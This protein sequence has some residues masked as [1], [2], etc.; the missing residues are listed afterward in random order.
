MIVTSLARTFQAA[1]ELFSWV[2]SQFIWRVPRNVR[3]WS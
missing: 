1:F 3:G 2:L